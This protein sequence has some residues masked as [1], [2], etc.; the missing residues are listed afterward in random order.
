MA[1]ERRS[2][3][4]QEKSEAQL[5]SLKLENSESIR[6]LS[7]I[8]EKLSKDVRKLEVQLQSLEEK[9]LGV[10]T[11]RE[12][13]LE[14]A[15]VDAKNRLQRAHR[16]WEADESVTFEKIFLSRRES[17][18]K[19][20]ADVFGPRLDKLVRDGK[21]LVASMKVDTEKKLEQKRHEF[22]I[23]SHRKL[24]KVRA[25]LEKEVDIE[26][27]KSEKSHEKELDDCRR[28]HE[29]NLV[30]QREKQQVWCYFSLSLVSAYFDSISRARY[31]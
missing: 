14:K 21:A 28:K 17:I 3:K 24:Q 26:I 30:I 10:N 19:Q 18:E 7:A 9:R 22:A 12:I 2:A 15:K 23:E 4:C 13:A 20:T 29:N 1:K 5:A 25:R 6:K 8:H 16:Q 27:V 31:Q 11:D